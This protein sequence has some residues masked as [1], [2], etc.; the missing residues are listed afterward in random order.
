MDDPI[1]QNR[2]LSLSPEYQEFIMSD[3]IST[4][5][6]DLAEAGNLEEQ[7]QVVLSNGL[8]LYMLYF[9]DQ[10][11]LISFLEENDFIPEQATALV[12]AFVSILPEEYVSAHDDIVDELTEDIAEEETVEENMD[13]P[14]DTEVQTGPSEVNPIRTMANDMNIA[15]DP[16][17][18]NT[19]SSSQSSVL[20]QNT[21]TPDD[22]RWQQ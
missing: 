5:S 20:E 19:Y 15:R 14:F 3:F 1:I 11:D 21:N 12:N 8:L 17:G 13:T 7:D 10:A 4:A 18:T 9:L 16:D 6:F 22:S 2:I